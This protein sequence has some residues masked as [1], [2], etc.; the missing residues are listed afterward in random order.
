MR[1]LFL[2]RGKQQ[3]IIPS[4][5]IITSVVHFTIFVKNVQQI[6]WVVALYSTKFK[7]T[8][9]AS[10]SCITPLVISVSP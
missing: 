7:L 10:R 4:N 3:L 1:K 8:G 2:L 5:S 6:G 9:I